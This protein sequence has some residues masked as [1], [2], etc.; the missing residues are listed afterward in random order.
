MVPQEKKRIRHELLMALYEA[1]KRVAALETALAHHD[2]LLGNGV[3]RESMIGKAAPAS[4]GSADPL[5]HYLGM[6]ES[7]EDISNFIGR[8]GHE[9]SRPRLGL[10]APPEVRPDKPVPL[11]PLVGHLVEGHPNDA[12][13]F[14]FDQDGSPAVAGAVVPPERRGGDAEA[15]LSSEVLFPDSGAASASGGVR[16]EGEPPKPKHEVVAPLSADW[17]LCEMG[18]EDD[19]LRSCRIL[20]VFN[21]GIWDWDLRTGELYTSRRWQS[22]MGADMRRS[23][24]SPLEE[25]ARRIHPADIE[26]FRLRFDKLRAGA[27][28]LLNMT[29]RF[30]RGGASWGWGVLRAVSVRSGG[31]TLRIIAV[32][33]DITVQREAE[34]ALR[35]SDEK[36]RLLAED[37]PDVISRFDRQGRFLYV[38]PNFS[39]YSTMSSEKITGKRIQETDLRG[40]VSLFEENVRR[41]FE[42]GIPFQEEIQFISPLVGDVV[43]DCRFWPEFGT[44]GRVVSVSAVLRDMTFPRR[45]EESYYALFNTMDDGFSLFEHVSSWVAG[46]S[47]HHANEFALV[48]MNPS[49]ARL[50]SLEASGTLGKPLD[51]LMGEDAELW[52]GC[53]R[54]VLKEGRPITHFL[55]SIAADRQFAISAYSP[56]EGRVAC[57]VKD[58]TQ[59]RRIEREVHLNEA[60]VTALYRMPHMDDAPEGDVARFSLDQALKLTGSEIGYLFVSGGHDRGEDRLYWSNEVMARFKNKPLLSA[61]PGLPWIKGSDWQALR[62]AEVVN[63]VG[64]DY[65]EAF[66]HGVPVTRYMLA[67]VLEEGRVVCIAGVANKDKEYRPGDL[68]QLELFLGGMWFHLRR[69]WNVQALQR[70]KE[71]AEAASRAKNEFLAN[72]SHELRTPLNGILGML[73]VLQ[74]SPLSGA[75]MEW[76]ITANYSGRSLLRI[77]SD[78]LDFSR[79]EAGSFELAPQLFDFSATVRSALGMFIH[80]AEEKK[81]RF[82][83]KMDGAIP[84]V[85]VGDDARVRQIIV[86]LVGNAFKFTAQGEISIECALLPHSKAGKRRIYLAVEDTGIGI[87][88]EKLGDIFRAFTQIDGSSTRRYAGT[89]LGLA[90]VCKLVGLMGGALGVESILGGGTIVHCS[91]PFDEP[92]QAMDVPAIP[93]AAPDA[94]L[95]LDILVV[96][97][98]PINQFTLRTLLRQAGHKSV[99]VGNGRQAL[100]ALVLHPFECIITDIQ[101]PVMDGVELVGRIRS[102]DTTGIEPSPKV[103]ALLGMGAENGDARFAVAEDIPVLALTAHAMTGDRERFLDMGM[104]YYLAKPVFAAELSATLGHISMLLHARRET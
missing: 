84:S 64:G 9:E 68:R 76:V 15:G 61:L 37:S 55:S 22:I 57:I 81:I 52:A 79:I 40:E 66:G 2:A 34:I 83:L 92:G 86:N 10:D 99:C 77:I 73:Q 82:S 28:S 53:L 35:A 65:G 72:V 93:V 75:Q 25:L 85:L 44:D 45:M 88:E 24:E 6:V 12:L 23:G 32:L 89:G 20:Q 30:K 101:M 19:C 58:V 103:R 27:T 98:D 17:S 96:E 100:E 42:V 80:Q 33:G 63:T 74:R 8:E 67:P 46:T 71:A 47:V 16:Q 14:A 18:Q 39:R 70:A 48:V 94:V 69:R 102:G 4:A 50:F 49:F 97:D 87:P 43:A 54:R 38:S 41:V 3:D 26:I 90:I 95:P 59:L 104:D 51:E 7:E 13:A 31:E 1:R 60:R 56:E 36:F 11:S 62:A 91:L 29:L 78:I 5:Q 21:E